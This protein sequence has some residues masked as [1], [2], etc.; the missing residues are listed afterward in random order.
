MEGQPPLY[1]SP[2]LR[3]FVA[4]RIVLPLRKPQL[5]HAV[6]GTLPWTHSIYGREGLNKARVL[7]QLF[8][9]HGVGEYEIISVTIGQCNGALQ[10]ALCVVEAVKERAAATLGLSGPQFIVVFDHADVLCYEPDNETSMLD[11]IALGERC[12]RANV[13]VVALFD[14]VPGE[15]AADRASNFV[16]A[17]HNRFFAQFSG[18]VGYAAVPSED[19]RERLFRWAIGAFVAHM[20]NELLCELSDEH[21]KELCMMSTWT[22]PEQMLEWLNRSFRQLIED[23]DMSR[24]RVILSMDFLTRFNNVHKTPRGPH[25]MREDMQALESRFSEACGQGPVGGFVGTRDMPFRIPDPKVTT[26]S[27]ENADPEA[28]KVALHG[29]RQRLVGNHTDE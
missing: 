16:R 5:Y 9:E 21:Y 4:R 18:S 8:E 27:E 11:A 17:C 10:R 25:I 19:Y 28:A 24:S 3:D 23:A 12:A 26:F 29:K 14:R 13:M 2:A 7:Q 22:S 6:T 15:L 20:G 1:A